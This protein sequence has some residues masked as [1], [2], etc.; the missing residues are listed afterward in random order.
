MFNS[1]FPRVWN[2]EF[3]ELYHERV[4]YW[5]AC[6]S[7]RQ[8][9]DLIS[10]R[11]A[12]AAAHVLIGSLLL[13]LSHPSTAVM[14]EGRGAPPPRPPTTPP[15]GKL[16]S[17]MFNK[18]LDTG[19]NLILC[20]R[21]LCEHPACWTCESAVMAPGGRLAFLLRNTLCLLHSLTADWVFASLAS[22]GKRHWACCAEVRLA[23]VPDHGL[24]RRRGR[25]YGDVARCFVWWDE[26]LTS[27][28]PPAWLFASSEQEV[29]SWGLR[30]HRLGP[31]A[32]SE[33]EIVTFF[34]LW[35]FQ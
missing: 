18:P 11:P 20:V 28:M 33:G 2:V 16:V 32:W 22:N 6:S 1:W 21:L 29:T 7:V 10:G 13:L 17:L 34:F 8:Q 4:R 3:P 5:Y 25:S 15:V 9:Q 24:N 23:S 35:H 19:G 26:D 30:G 12:V 14:R 31:K 27:E